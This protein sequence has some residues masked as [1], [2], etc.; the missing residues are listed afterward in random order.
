LADWCEN[1]AAVT[2][3]LAAS[4]LNSDGTPDAVTQLLHRLVLVFNADHACFFNFPFFDGYQEVRRTSSGTSRDSNAEPS[5]ALLDAFESIDWDVVTSS[6]DNIQIQNNAGLL[7]MPVIHND[8]C[9]ACLGIAPSS[10]NE[11]WPRATIDLLATAAL[12]LG[13]VLDRRAVETRLREVCDRFNLT[14]QLSGLGMWDWN[15]ATGELYWSYTIAPLLGLSANRDMKYEEFLDTVHP[16][17][18][19]GIQAAVHRSIEEDVPFQ[20]EHRIIRPDGETRWMLEKGGIIRDDDGKAIRMLGVVKDITARRATERKLESSQRLLRDE[21]ARRLSDERQQREALIREV[22]HRIKNNLQGILGLLRQELGEHPALAGAMENAIS[23]VRSIAIIHGL[24]SRGKNGE[25]YLCEIVE[26][27]V[28]AVKE[29]L[30]KSITLRLETKIDPPLKILSE[31][32]VPVALILNELLTNAIKHAGSGDNTLDTY[33][34][35]TTQQDRGEIRINNPASP[36]WK[37]FDLITGKGLGTGLELVRSLLPHHG[38]SLDI[39]YT[40]DNKRVEA[41]FVLTAPIIMAAGQDDRP[42]VFGEIKNNNTDHY[43]SA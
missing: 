40:N 11:V 14:S 10:T 16:D 8:H 39:N 43:Y 34:E 25:I 17:D 37:D 6:D 35:F 19:D 13:E 4:V 30:G 26:A 29:V 42:P 41:R 5:R 15:I 20:F 31:E 12:M 18:R 38:A 32:A 22:H 9:I 21:E 3:E 27:I 1:T 23:K 24:Q 36:V 7:L 28:H 2:R 33:I